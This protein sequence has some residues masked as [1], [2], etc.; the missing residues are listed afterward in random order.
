[1]A[2]VH[3]HG[4][5]E[6]RK[7]QAHARLLRGREFVPSVLDGS[8]HADAVKVGVLIRER[9]RDGGKIKWEWSGVEWKVSPLQNLK[10]SMP[11]EEDGLVG[12]PGVELV[13]E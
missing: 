3:P 5:E 2:I 9:E 4:N 7:G 8:E 11:S 6:V 13:V 1:M 12:V 10:G